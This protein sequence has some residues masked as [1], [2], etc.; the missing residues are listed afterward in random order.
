[1]DTKTAGHR[2]LQFGT[3]D[4]FSIDIILIASYLSREQKILS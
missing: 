2:K 4:H 3:K 1:M